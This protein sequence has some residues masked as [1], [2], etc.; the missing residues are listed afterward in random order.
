MFLKLS[1]A[2]RWCAYL[3]DH[4]GCWITW[5]IQGHFGTVSV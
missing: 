3:C 1:L 5:H 2:S 4:C